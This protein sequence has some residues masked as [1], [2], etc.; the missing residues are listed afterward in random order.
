VE[1]EN[2]TRI[3]VIAVGVDDFSGVLEFTLG[4]NVSS[5]EEVDTAVAQARNAGNPE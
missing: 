3:T 5:K 1:H 2:G 4:H